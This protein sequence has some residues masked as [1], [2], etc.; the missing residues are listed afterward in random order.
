MDV[1]S[2]LNKEVVTDFPIFE[3]A[4]KLEPGVYVVT[5]RPWKGSDKNA[6]DDNSGNLATQWLVVSDL[7]LATLSGEDGL[8][9]L[10]RSLATAAPLGGVEVKLIA[11][12]N[13][14]LASKSTDAEG[15]VDFD[16]G[17]TRGT[18]GSAPSLIVAST[19][20][21]DYNFLSLLQ[22]AFDLTDRGVTGRDAPKALDAFVFTERGV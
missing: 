19:A 15:R 1:A 13:E 5:A 12:N 16:P 17:L 14:V 9:A 4:G 8:H 18:G 11:R 2:E 21:G 22:N 20:D 10:V 7:G 3:A 6:S